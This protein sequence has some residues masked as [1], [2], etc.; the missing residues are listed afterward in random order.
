M[1]EQTAPI[2]S[3][4]RP[5]LP[6]GV[7]LAHSEAHGGFAAFL[8]GTPIAAELMEHSSKAQSEYQANGLCNLLRQHHCLAQHRAHRNGG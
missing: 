6:H 4:A 7:R 2:A 3:D 8:G 1:S 5:R